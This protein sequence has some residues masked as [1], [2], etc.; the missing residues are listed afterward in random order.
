MS[1][2]KIHKCKKNKT[3]HIYENTHAYRA[4]RLPVTIL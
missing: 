4:V 1:D 2:H 3:V